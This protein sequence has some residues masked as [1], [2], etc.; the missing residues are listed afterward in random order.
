LLKNGSGR[1]GRACGDFVSGIEELPSSYPTGSSAR[2]LLTWA[3]PH[4]N[5]AD[6]IGRYLDDINQ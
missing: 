2:V 6:G 5:S 1:Q 4:S 3:L